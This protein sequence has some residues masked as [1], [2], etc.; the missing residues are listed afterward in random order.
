MILDLMKTAAFTEG[1]NLLRDAANGKKVFGST[2]HFSGCEYKTRVPAFGAFVPALIVLL[3][4]AA[5]A[6]LR[7]A[8]KEKEKTA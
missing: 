8:G 4:L 1:G 7:R 2:G 3:L 5:A 6:L